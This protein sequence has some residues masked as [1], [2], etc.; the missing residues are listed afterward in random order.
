MERVE[1]T[2][3]GEEFSSLSTRI[4]TLE[5]NSG[6]FQ[7]LPSFVFNALYVLTYSSRRSKK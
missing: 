3:L 2:Q 7:H 6:D 5:K 1:K 4:K